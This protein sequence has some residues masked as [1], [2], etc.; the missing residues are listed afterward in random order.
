MKNE[1]WKNIEGYEGLYQVSNFGRVKSLKFGKEKILKPLRIKCGYLQVNLSKNGKGKMCYVHR[2]VA[3]A[4][5]PNP[6][7]LSEVNHKDENKENNRVDNLEWCNR[8]YNNNY[9][10]RNKKIGEKKLI[11]VLQY[12]KD[13]TFIREWKSMIDVENELGIN[14]S[15]ITQCCR[16][17]LKSAGGFR[18]AYK[19]SICYF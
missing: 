10:T 12:D 11:P 18:W 8:T 13:G 17:K 6:N 16:G 19:N 7:C 4:F 5:I 15:N 2:L 9:G 3:L 14:N 1:V